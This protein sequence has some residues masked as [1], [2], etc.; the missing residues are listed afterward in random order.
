MAAV[1]P[2]KK[3][4][5]QVGGMPDPGNGLLCG[6]SD[7]CRRSNRIASQRS[8]YLSRRAGRAAPQGR[9]VPRRPPDLLPRRPSA[10][11]IKKLERQSLLKWLKSQA[12]LA[13]SRSSHSWATTQGYLFALVLTWATLMEPGK[14]MA[15]ES[16]L[17]VTFK[18]L[19][20]S[21]AKIAVL[22]KKCRR[23]VR[24]SA[25]SPCALHQRQHSTAERLRQFWPGGHDAGQV[26]IRLFPTCWTT[27][28]ETARLQVLVGLHLGVVPVR[29]VNP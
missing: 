25:R 16:Y 18:G 24:L 27:C 15:L 2:L 14:T 19:R 5:L 1:W 23:R 21:S 4:S 26:G 9:C 29:Q 8:T 3:N 10:S 7:C 11:R 12:I 22:E 17:A 28:E 13:E 6:T 20:H